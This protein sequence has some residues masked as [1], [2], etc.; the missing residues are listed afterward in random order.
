M[1]E[2]FNDWYVRVDGL[3][4]SLAKKTINKNTGEDKFVSMY[5]FNSLSGALKKFKHIIASERLEDAE[6]TLS[7]ALKT[8]SDSNKEV[9]DFI[10]KAIG[11]LE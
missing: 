3:Q 9:E 4:Y 6:I 1:I 10:D 11:E 2:L 7:E 8:I 5:F